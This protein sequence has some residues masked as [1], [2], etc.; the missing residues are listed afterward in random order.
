M[1]EKLGYSNLDELTAAVV[2]G[3][4]ADNSPLELAAGISEEQALSE[5]REL[6]NKNRVLRSLMGQGY[7]GTHTP[8]VIHRNVLENPAWYTAYTPCQPEITG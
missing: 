6:D 5:L 1:L 4:I 7:Y 8:K 2:P 3:S